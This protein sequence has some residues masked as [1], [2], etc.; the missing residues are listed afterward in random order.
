MPDKN[1]SPETETSICQSNFSVGLNAIASLID[2]AQDDICRAQR[3]L[4]Q[5]GEGVARSEAAAAK[6]YLNTAMVILNE[7]G[8]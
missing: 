8:I 6:E 4:E 1:E 2:R 3:R 5:K 7:I